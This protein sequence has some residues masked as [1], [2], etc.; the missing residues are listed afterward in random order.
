MRVTVKAPKLDDTTEEVLVVEWLVDVG[1]EVS[2]GQ[3]L[4]TVEGDKVEGELPSPV[5]G[6]VVE[7]LAEAEDE[8]AVGTPLA[9]IET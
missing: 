3:T 6:R 7:R 4:V 8:V 2:E 5:A 9:I 1:D